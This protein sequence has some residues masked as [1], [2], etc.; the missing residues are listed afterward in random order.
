MLAEHLK[1]FRVSREVSS[2]KMSWLRAWK[3]RRSFF[4]IWMAPACSF[5]RAE[6]AATHLASHTSRLLQVHLGRLGAR[7]GNNGVGG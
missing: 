6:Q 5:L 3:M 4:R 7:G 1:S 2:L